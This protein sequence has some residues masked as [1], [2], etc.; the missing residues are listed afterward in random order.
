[1]TQPLLIQNIVID[2]TSPP[3]AAGPGISR[4]MWLQP[5]SQLRKQ[6]SFQ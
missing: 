3:L 1:M 4:Q 2:A 6:L 5:I